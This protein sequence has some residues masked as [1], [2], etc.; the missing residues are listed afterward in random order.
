VDYLLAALLLLPALFIA[1]NNWR[2]GLFAC[3]VVAI[4]Q[5]P[6]RKLAPG[7]PAYYILLVGVVLGAAWLAA[8]SRVPLDPNRI[9]GWRRNLST[10][11][12]LFLL[13]LAAQAANAYLRFGN[14]ML[15]AVGLLS[16]LAPLPALVLGYQFAIRTGARGIARWLG[17]YLVVVLIALATVYLQYLGLDWPVLGEVGSGL[18]IHDSKQGVILIAYSG[19]FRASEVA[20]WHSATAICLLFLLGT[21]RRLTVSRSLAVLAI[22]GL[23]IGIG[24]LTGRRKL[25]VQVAIFLSAYLFF[26][27]AFLRGGRKVAVAAVLAGL[28]AYLGSVGLLDSDPGENRPSRQGLRYQSYV[29]RS[30]NVFEDIPARFADLGV[31]PIGWAVNQF[32]LFGAGLGLGSQGS[33]FFTSNLEIG[34]TGAAEGGLGK[35]TVELGVLGLLLSAWLAVAML[36]HIW[37]L[38]RFVSARSLRLARLSYGLLAFLVANGAS[39]TVA[40]QVF[41][42]IFVLLI[43]GLTLGFLLAMPVLAERE[44]RNAGQAKSGVQPGASGLER[45]AWGPL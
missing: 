30:Q 43:L 16:Y 38:L 1:F 37:R 4:L 21:E 44:G 11:F 18:T 28:L 33:R 6:L 27:T 20:A 2:H 10:P 31:A 25:V 8:L 13:L 26:I 39:F 34:D 19:S 7:E 32:G 35:L 14:P 42:D 15:P 9:A 22:V 23:L 29:E 41:S 24:I 3:V 40:T 5:D 45:P 36:R 17:F 12:N